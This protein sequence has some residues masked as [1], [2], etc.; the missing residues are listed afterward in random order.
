[1]YNKR[2]WLVLSFLTLLLVGGLVVAMTRG[3]ANQDPTPKPEKLDAFLG[4]LLAT[5]Q[6]GVQVLPA[7][8]PSQFETAP[9]ADASLPLHKDTQGRAF[10]DVLIKTNGSLDGLAGLGV[11]VQG[12]VGTVVAARV[13]V[14]SVARLSSLPNVEFVETARRLSPT[15]DVNVPTTGASP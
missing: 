5:P 6:G 9:R 10:V 8:T 14:D 2:L 1:M 13:P 3:T 15:N 11:I 12:V 4:G 7:E